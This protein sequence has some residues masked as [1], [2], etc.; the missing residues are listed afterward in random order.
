[1]LPT[2]ALAFQRAHAIVTQQMRAGGGHQV[3]TGSL[4]AMAI[5]PRL[6]RY[7]DAPT[8]LGMDRNRF[9]AEVR[10][11][12][13]EIPIGVQGVAFDRLELDTWA[14]QY[15]ACNGRPGRKKGNSI[16]DVK[17]RRVSTNVAVF[18][19][20]TSASAGGEFARALTRLAS[21]KLNASSRNS[22]KESGKQVSME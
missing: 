22:Q 13:T 5:L 8:Y 12:V 20:S 3:N 6:I 1:M 2:E 4:V 15:K 10:G 16:W 18:G 9:N 14:D 7:R 11:F 21:K 19:T 17:G